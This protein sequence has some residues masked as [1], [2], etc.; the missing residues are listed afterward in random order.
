MSQHVRMLISSMMK[1]EDVGEIFINGIIYPYKSDSTV[2]SKETREALSKVKNAK[3]LNIHVNSPGGIVTEA[4]DMMD[5]IREHTA[6]EKNVHV[7]MADSAATLIL[8]VATHVSM[9][10]GG[11]IMIHRPSG[12]MWGN[13]DDMLRE[14][15]VLT[16]KEKEICSMY[17]AFCKQPESDVWEKMNKETWFTAQQAKDYGFVHEVI[18]V[19]DDNKQSMITRG[20]MV[21]LGYMNVPEWVMNRLPDK[22]EGTPPSAACGQHRT[23]GEAWSIGAGDNAEHRPSEAQVGAKAPEGGIDAESAA[24]AAFSNITNKEVTIMT[25]E[26][27]RQQHPDIVQQIENAAKQSGVNEE[28][29]RMQALDKVALPGY[30]QMVKDA[31][32]GDKP[33][34]AADVSMQ[35]V[36]AQMAK[37]PNFI[38]TRQQ[39]T[40]TMKEVPA[41]EV[42]GKPSDTAEMDKMSTMCAGFAQ[43]KSTVKVAQ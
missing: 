16:K 20:Q 33:L 8:L 34:T 1:S 3:K 9:I 6:K 42:P 36:E 14:H 18:K 21:M 35:I 31:K 38:A 41:A 10:E 7:V 43:D 25:L 26:E 23:E 28:R 4:V 40:A 27:L 5:Q 37:G 32:Y 39:E 30:E 12:G 22:E 29:A 2:S 13:A 11:E 17:A 19:V 24:Q 15:E